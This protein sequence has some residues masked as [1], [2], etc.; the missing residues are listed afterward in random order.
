MVDRIVPATTDDDRETVARSLGLRDAWPVVTE[1]F[2][3]W[4]VEDNFPL[5]R[6]N[7]DIG[8]AEF[9]ADV[10][11]YEHMKLRLLNGAHTTIALVSLLAGK[12]TV[13]EAM[14]DA[15]I[16]DLVDLLWSEVSPTSSKSLDVGA[17]TDRL[18]RRFRNEALDHRVNQIASDTSLKLPQR[19]VAPLRD[20]HGLG[21]PCGALVFA[22]AAWMRCCL[23]R[24]DSGAP[25]AFDDP[26]LAAWSARPDG[27]GASSGDTVDAFLAFEP[28]FRPD[29]VT[30]SLRAPLIGALDDITSNGV[31]GAASA[32]LAAVQRPSP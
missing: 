13:A 31:L 1:P 24:A 30:A 17:Y 10:E 29:A 21:A 15:T 26:A 6:P 22:L 28:V 20:L 7:W 14:A 8:G 5:G 16:A 27:A 32:H 4:V 3:Q 9:V 11:P 12:T 25:I 2:C 19:I 18:R 23:G